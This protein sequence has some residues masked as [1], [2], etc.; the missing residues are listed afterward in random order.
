[1]RKKYFQLQTNAYQYL[2]EKFSKF[3]FVSDYKQ[4]NDTYS[5]YVIE[6]LF[7]F[8][9]KRIL[10]IQKINTK[11]LVGYY[12]YLINRPKL[13]SVGLLSTSSIAKHIFSI[14]LFF[15]FLYE[16]KQIKGKVIFPKRFKIKS[17]P[18]NILTSDEVKL[19]YSF[20]EDKRDLTILSIAYGC[21]VR[22][23]EMEALNISDFQINNNILIIRNG[24][25][26]KRRDIP[27]SSTI[28]NNLKNYILNERYKYIIDQTPYTDAFLL[29]NYGR[30]MTGNQL[31][32][33]LKY[34]VSKTKNQLLI[35]KNITLHSL[36]HSIT[37]HLL[38]NG[39]DIEFVRDF[40]GHS[41]I[42]TVHVYAKRRKM[43][44]GIGAVP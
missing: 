32:Y 29:N 43:K 1:M 39:A 22:R 17:S 35:D 28:A 27:L 4:K 5:L 8:E 2:L 23:S 9:N 21:G 14:N 13:R 36:R 18:R 31:N 42:D 41:E 20:I 25:F 34:L 11:D 37:V 3:L 6:F 10:N 30:R 26:G 19:L 38:D 16:E 12:E 24:K 33:R 15:D 44:W 40:L 7:Y